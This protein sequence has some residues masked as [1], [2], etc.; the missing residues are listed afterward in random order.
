MTILTKEAMQ[1]IESIPIKGRLESNIPLA[2]FTW[3]KVGG[4]ADYL[5]RP[6]DSADLCHFLKALPSDVPLMVMGAASNLLVRD[7]G[8][9]GVV[10]RL[11]RGF[12]D[13][14]R[15]NA[16]DVM[17]GAGVP[18]INAAK[19]LMTEGLGGGAFLRG[20]PGT[21]GGALKM[22]AGAYGTEL[23][24]IFLEACGVTLQGE[25]VT[26]SYDE[27]QFSYR[28]CGMQDIIFTGVKLRLKEADP[29]I[30][31]AQMHDITSKRQETQPVKSH[32]GG[33]T[34]KNPINNLGGHKAWAL[35]DQA[36]CRGLQIGNAQISQLH[37]NFMLNNGD[38]TAYDLEFLGE[39]V[40]EKVFKQSQIMLEWEIK[41]IGDFQ[42]GQVILNQS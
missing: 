25:A 19:F 41:R 32:T 29:K 26:L 3:F 39:T 18:D 6:S 4:K 16:T 8:I 42:D 7:G 37:C 5:Y 21:I 14:V 17:I 38:A 20:I 2:P 10:M 27:M 11:G 9:R 15:L 12:A 30:I 13:M 40:R 28:H 36:G 23:K 24:D 35:I 34:F 33:S 1:S 22:N 31:A